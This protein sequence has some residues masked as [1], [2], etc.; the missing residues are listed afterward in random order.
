M[1]S[2]GVS[3]NVVHGGTYR[4]ARR[5]RVMILG[6]LRLTFMVP[7]DGKSTHSTAQKIKDRLWSKFKVAVSELPS[8]GTTQ[9]IIGGALDGYEENQTRERLDQIV[10]HLNDWG[11]VDLVNDDTELVHFD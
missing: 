8:P 7:P 3:R 2:T 1:P 6:A 10:R 11:H 9:L 5:E 4:L